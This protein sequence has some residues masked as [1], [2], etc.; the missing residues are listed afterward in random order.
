MLNICCQMLICF[1]EPR[2]KMLNSCTWYHFF[3][4]LMLKLRLDC[5]LFL[6]VATSQ[7]QRLFTNH[8]FNFECYNDWR[9]TRRLISGSTN[10]TFQK[11]FT[12]CLQCIH[13]RIWPILVY[14]QR[15]MNRTIRSGYT[16]LCSTLNHSR[17]QAHKYRRDLTHVC[18]DP[19]PCWL[20][21]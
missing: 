13:T 16:A 14:D 9:Q 5:F 10:A 4:V 6:S 21:E 7:L 2:K 18:L 19:S 1:G 12:R 20:T 11:H 8:N 15:Q 17:I 3:T